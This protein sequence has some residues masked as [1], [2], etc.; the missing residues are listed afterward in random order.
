MERVCKQCGTSWPGY[1]DRCPDCG[2]RLA[3][4]VP[5]TQDGKTSANKPA[6]ENVRKVHKLPPGKYYYPVWKCMSKLERGRFVSFWVTNAL[7]IGLAA[8]ALVLG[9]QDWFSLACGFSLA[10]CSDWLALRKSFA[11]QVKEA[12]AGRMSMQ[13]LRG[14]GDLVFEWRGAL[15]QLN[16]AELREIKEKGSRTTKNQK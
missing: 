1:M 13:D 10:A 9:R 8:A 16:K 3:E 7:A 11:R 2:I 6:G 5:S 4:P 15:F 14:A 12:C